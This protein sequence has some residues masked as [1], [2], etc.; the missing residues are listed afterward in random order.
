[1]PGPNKDE[2]EMIDKARQMASETV[3]LGGDETG[4]PTGPATPSTP[5]GTD[6]PDNEVWGPY[7][8]GEYHMITPPWGGNFGV[9]VFH[10]LRF[11]DVD[12]LVKGEIRSIKIPVLR[13]LSKE[14]K[15][16]AREQLEKASA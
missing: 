4:P 1:M 9:P 14:M 16:A 5:T 11:N 6:D 7:S 8:D 2:Q 10:E 12:K 15:A 3:P 13:D